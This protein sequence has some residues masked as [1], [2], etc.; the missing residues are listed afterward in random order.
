MYFRSYV[1]WTYTFYTVPKYLAWFSR[2]TYPKGKG[3][4]TPYLGQYG[5]ALLKRVPFSMISQ[6]EE[7]E[8]AG[9]S[10]CLDSH[11]NRD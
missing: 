3:G 11:H 9:K 7:Y 1:N 10:E 8:R 6:V 2:D 5:E 4:S